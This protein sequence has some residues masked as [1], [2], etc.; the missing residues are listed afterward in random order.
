MKRIW[1]IAAALLLV[2]VG[3]VIGCRQ[4][5]QQLPA[6]LCSEEFQRYAGRPGYRLAYLSDF[7]VNDSVSLPVTTITA[8]DSAAWV[9][10][11]NIFNI[12][13]PTELGKEHLTEG[14]DNVWF[15]RYIPQEDEMNDAYNVIALMFSHKTQ[16]ISMFYPKNEEEYMAVFIYTIKKGLSNYHP[17]KNK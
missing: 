10:L 15:R 13:E 14:I 12:P 2:A 4:R 3:I 1:V 17:N 8:T 7:P 6:G 9:Q 11:K 5:G 16:T